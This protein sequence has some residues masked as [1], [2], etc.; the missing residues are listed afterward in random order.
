M[1]I[2]KQQ[3]WA[4]V[5]AVMVLGVVAVAFSL[6]QRASGAQTTQ[7]LEQGADLGPDTIAQPGAADAN[8]DESTETDL[9]AQ[10]GSEEGLAGGLEESTAVASDESTPGEPEPSFG[11]NPNAGDFGTVEGVSASDTGSDAIAEQYQNQQDSQDRMHRDFDNY[12]KGE[13]TLENPTTG[14]VMQGEAGF[15]SYYQSPSVDVATGES[16]IVGTEGGYTPPA[17]ATQLNVV[18]SDSGS[19]T[20]TGSEP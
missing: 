2:T 14:E 12:I 3:V 6:G 5:A 13:V 1:N 20:S 8:L 15:D 19:S 17:D 16:T 9:N 10:N 7:V 11:V 4:A 18:G